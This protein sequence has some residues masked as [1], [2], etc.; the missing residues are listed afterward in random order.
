ML[1]LTEKETESLTTSN[2]AKGSVCDENKKD[3]EKSIF[4]DLEIFL[5][6]MRIEEDN[7]NFILQVK[8]VI[9]FLIRHQ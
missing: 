8:F 7:S 2:K 6:I 3:D 5:K 4:Q 1:H 9:L